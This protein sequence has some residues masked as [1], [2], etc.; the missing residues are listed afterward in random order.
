MLP[1]FHSNENRNR[2]SLDWSLMICRVM[3]LFVKDKTAC[4]YNIMTVAGACHE[5][6]GRGNIGFSKKWYLA[7]S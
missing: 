2:N 6:L 7:I 3:K 1:S 5:G 4:C